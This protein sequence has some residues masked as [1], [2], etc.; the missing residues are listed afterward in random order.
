MAAPSRVYT[1]ARMAE[2][3]GENEDLPHETSTQLEPEDGRLWICD[4]GDRE[5]DAAAPSHKNPPR[6]PMDAG[7][8][9]VLGSRRRRRPPRGCPGRLEGAATAT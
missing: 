4:T 6:L 1:A 2:M 8:G 3:L 7:I 5:L 9:P